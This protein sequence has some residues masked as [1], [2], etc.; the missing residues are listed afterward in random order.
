MSAKLLG[1]TAIGNGKDTASRVE[2]VR[3]V[4]ENAISDSML[5]G[6]RVKLD[7]VQE[8]ANF[9][10]MVTA[11]VRKDIELTVAASSLRVDEDIMKRDLQV[12]SILADGDL[13]NP[14]DLSAAE[15]ILSMQGR[16]LLAM[17]R[18]PSARTA[19]IYVSCISRVRQILS[20]KNGTDVLEAMLDRAVPLPNGKT[21][22]PQDILDHVTS[23]FTEWEG[24]H[25]FRFIEVYDDA[26]RLRKAVQSRKRELTK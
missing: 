15:G 19:Y 4:E 5:D 12:I 7:T 18:L 17:N 9:C 10:I 13:L 1:S 26:E 16:T 2:E 11:A 6:L 21:Q 20:G 14:K 25:G 23:L 24:R 3:D 22:V 8:K